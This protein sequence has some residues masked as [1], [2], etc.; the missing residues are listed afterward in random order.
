M[1]GTIIP[2]VRKKARDAQGKLRTNLKVYDVRYNVRDSATGQLVRKMKRGFLRRGDAEA[3]LLNINQEQQD[4][5]FVQSKKILLKDYLNDW[6]D[7]YVKVN[8]KA[9][10]YTQYVSIITQRLI[11]WAGGQ[12][13]KTITPMKIDKFYAQLLQNG[14]MDGKGGLS[15]KTVLYIHRVFNEA[16]NHA[17]RK[18]LLA[19]NPMFSVNNVPRPQK[20]QAAIYS[21]A[22][23]HQL[24]TAVQDSFYWRSAI[25]L[26]GI[27]GLRR[28]ECL[29]L[30][31]SKINFEQK[32]ICI[33]EQLVEVNKLLSF[34]TPKS[35]ES[36]RIINAPDEVFAILARRKA[37]LEQYKEWLGTLY[38]DND[39]VICHDNGEPVR[40]R[41]F[42]HT[43][44]ELLIRHNL[45]CI[46]FHDLR[47][48]CA[49]LM[50]E[51]GVAMK[52]A[53]EILGHS[54]IA[55]TADLYTHV[56]QKTKKEAA[57]KIG[58]FVFGNSKQEA[59]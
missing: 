42:T 8:V 28:G 30:K 1:Q 59:E 15:A 27:C 37:E 48:S 34:S 19:R 23:L 11:P 49:S 9:S 39:L 29:G 55:I 6:L 24:L 40:P 51:S 16:L 52:T 50:L 2:R 10:T 43:F 58:A 3:F 57:N 13:L 7:T 14:R 47:H 12:D 36:T 53:S 25:I 26:A 20:F 46:R 54:T 31:W 44:R 32:T 18:G 21:V 33:D 17:V 5:I 45:R 41:H 22:E 35:A 56:Q 4:G 38:H